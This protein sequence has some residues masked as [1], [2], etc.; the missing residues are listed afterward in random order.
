V[1][2][3]GAK[4]AFS[5]YVMHHLPQYWDAPERFDP[6]R[7]TPEQSAG[8]PQYAYMPFGGGP[9]RCV[10]LRFAQLEGQFLLAIL[11]Q[12]FSV[13]PKPGAVTVATAKITLQPLPG[14]ELFLEPRAAAGTAH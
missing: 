8:R 10:G 5:P 1:I 14:V 4:V 13:R 9:R 3:R 12:S 6:G 11:G 7:F 2:P